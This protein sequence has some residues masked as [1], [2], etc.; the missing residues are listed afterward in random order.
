[1]E[2]VAVG[3]LCLLLVFFIRSWHLYLITHRRLLLEEERSTNILASAKMLAEVV[4][5]ERTDGSER[6]VKSTRDFCRYHPP[7]V[8][9][10]AAFEGCRLNLFNLK[11][12]KNAMWRKT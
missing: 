5:I 1:M 3:A 8:V 9:I 7:D 11:G 6:A 4:L 2:M 10:A 12:G